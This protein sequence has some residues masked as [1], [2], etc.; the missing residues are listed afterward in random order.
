MTMNKELKSQIINKFQQNSQDTGSVE[1]QVALLT[2]RINQL[3]QHLRANKHDFACNRGLLILV[4]R[5]KKFLKYI[6]RHN[7]AKYKEIIEKLGL[8]K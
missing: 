5:R 1:V 2:E 3:N 4:G 7:P 6:E 8:R